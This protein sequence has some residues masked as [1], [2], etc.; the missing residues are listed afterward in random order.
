[1]RNSAYRV[2]YRPVGQQISEAIR[3]FPNLETTNNRD[4]SIVF[5]DAPEFK[6]HFTINER[7][8]ET[9]PKIL[10]NGF[11]FT[12]SLTSFWQPTITISQIVNHLHLIALA[13]KNPNYSPGMSQNISFKGNLNSSMPPRFTKNHPDF[14]TIN[15]QNDDEKVK[16]N[17]NDSKSE[18]DDD[19]EIDLDNIDVDDDDHNGFDE[20]P[21]ELLNSSED[22]SDN[23][24]SSIR[25]HGNHKSNKAG[26]QKGSSKDNHKSNKN[27]SFEEEEEEVDIVLNIKEMNNEENEVGNK[28][29]K[30]SKNRKYKLKANAN[31]AAIQNRDIF[32]DIEELDAVVTESDEQRPKDN[33]FNNEF[34]EDDDDNGEE[35]E[36]EEM[37]EDNPTF[38][39]MI[40]KLGYLYLKKNID[41]IAYI[42][43]YKELK[44]LV[45]KEADEDE[46]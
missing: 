12:T 1:M 24:Y 7:F 3:Q 26:K 37:Y 14:N 33:E 23:K 21:T 9:S 35:D 36:E 34:D 16:H 38:D 44:K 5:S 41:T 15:E 19:D 27:E 2:I 13:R 43:Q 39:K 25:S 31:G 45:Q 4:F 29:K 18:V 40:R 11:D 28:A 10:L 46:L 32:L 6:F 42:Q 20:A 22:L 17:E 30:S 8:P